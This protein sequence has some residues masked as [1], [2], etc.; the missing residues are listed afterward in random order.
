MADLSK[1][2]SIIAKDLN[3]YYRQSCA[4]SIPELEISGHTIAVI[5][6]NGSGKSTF[7]KTL[8][9]LLT[10]KTGSLQSYSSENAPQPLTPEVHMAYAPENGAVFNDVSVENYLRMWCRFKHHN[11]NY[12][13][14]KGSELLEALSITSLLPKLG[15]ELS[16]GQRRRI[17]IAAGL[18]I[19]PRF[20][21][22]DEPFDGLDT[23]QSSQ[24]TS[25]IQSEAKKR[26]MLVST[27]RMDIAERICDAV[28]VLD[29]GKVSVCGSVDS[30]CQQLADRSIAL[31]FDQ[32]ALP[33][34][35]SIAQLLETAFPQLLVT[36]IGPQI[37]VTG[38]NMQPPQ[39]LDLLK[40]HNISPLSAIATR[41]SLVDA[42]SYHLRATGGSKIEPV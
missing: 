19:D 10:P 37:S 23:L 24:L 18:L 33:Q 5:G 34:I 22:F 42:M 16:K 35:S 17:Q 12:Y 9:E 20:F 6:H 13:K 8:L 31:D 36:A 41:C 21:L 14:Q 26:A 3:V 15:R 4:L 11:A 30:V 28:V 39:L 7:I 1:S 2:V 32:T 29:N 38:K 27:H 40:L 25:V